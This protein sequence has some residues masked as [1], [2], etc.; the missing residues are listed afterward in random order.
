VCSILWNAKESSAEC[1]NPIQCRKKFWP[2]RIEFE[3][4][5]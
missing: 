2:L 5:I 4:C 3:D 1:E